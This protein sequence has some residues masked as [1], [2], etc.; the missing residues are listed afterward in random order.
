LVSAVGFFPD[1]IT[2]Q[3]LSLLQSSLP[4][5][6]LAL[7]L[8]GEEGSLVF[9][10]QP[11]RVAGLEEWLE[12]GT[13]E[14]RQG[15]PAGWLLL[16][17]APWNSSTRSGCLLCLQSLE[18]PGQATV[19]ALSQTVRLVWQREESRRC[20]S[21]RSQLLQ[22]MLHQS[23]DLIALM[24]VDGRVFYHTPS[25]ARLLQWGPQQGAV[26][27]YLD[28]VHPDDRTLVRDRSLRVAGGEAIAAATEYR[29]LTQNRQQV[30][31]VESWFSNVESQAGIL[32][33]VIHSRDISSR[34][35]AAQTLLSRELR[36]R[37]LLNETRQAVFEFDASGVVTSVNDNWELVT[38]VSARCTLGRPLRDFFDL[39]ETFELPLHLEL[40]CRSNPRGWVELWLHQERDHHDRWWGAVLDVSER[41]VLRRKLQDVGQLVDH[42]SEMVFRLNQ[43]GRV[44]YHNSA[45]HVSA[46]DCRPGLLGRKFFDE[47]CLPEGFFVEE[48]LAEVMQAGVWSGQL[49]QA[50][51][52]GSCSLVA[53]HISKA[54]PEEGGFLVTCRDVTRQAHLEDQLRSSQRLASLGLL[55]GGV[56]HDFNNLL[57]VIQGNCVLEQ[58]F[59]RQRNLEST[60]YLS[61]IIE[62]TDRAFT[63]TRQLLNFAGRGPAAKV[64][65]DLIR[66]MPETIRLLNRWFPG[67]L[68]CQWASSLAEARVDFAPGQLQQV[69]LNLAINARDAMPRGGSLEVSLDGVETG[70][71]LSFRDTGTGMTE[72]QREKIFEPF[73]TT[74]GSKGTGLGL[75]V[76][77]G[78]VSAHG[79]HIEVQSSLGEGTTFLIYLR[80]ALESETGRA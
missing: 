20:E 76:V 17:I 32:F 21:W 45:G 46:S 64:T 54:S 49:H 29:L 51:A 11:W 16:R 18:E 4:H 3:V 10:D 59:R 9:P 7:R 58:D 34:K 52:D 31:C 36:Y 50:G 40:A 2:M 79:G 65:L 39:P 43:E 66:V 63:M 23:L 44:T 22:S 5:C 48:V 1:E 33:I 12:T 8:P 68:E 35:A 74:K 41:S 27:N 77:H 6:Q 37:K 30:H 56:A 13:L 42:V 57:Q 61:D 71:C 70:Y 80:K 55:V 28:W 24:Q 15:L 25:L 14:V 72:S 38:G 60:E 75:A 69:V 62:A 26:L 19:E 73:Y 53:A 78:I 47:F 67:E